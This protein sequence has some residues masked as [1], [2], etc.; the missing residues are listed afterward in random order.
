LQSQNQA[1]IRENFELRERLLT[2]IEE[3]AA[4]LEVCHLAE[5]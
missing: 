5:L 1:L 4:H 2:L 3:Y